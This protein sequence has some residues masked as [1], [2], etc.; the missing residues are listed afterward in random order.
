MTITEAPPDRI[1]YT[2]NDPLSEELSFVVGPARVSE[3]DNHSRSPMYKLKD[4]NSTRFERQ[5]IK[6]M[7]LNL[8]FVSF[9]CS[10][11]FVSGF[12]VYVVT[13]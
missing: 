9:Q 6:G 12:Y 3:S 2:A 11:Q 1:E 13:F 10:V 8:L 5:I 7:L 4:S